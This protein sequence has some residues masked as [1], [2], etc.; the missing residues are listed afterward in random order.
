MHDKNSNPLKLLFIAKSDND[1][2]NTALPATI[3]SSPSKD[4]LLKF[5]LNLIRENRNVISN[6]RILDFDNQLFKSGEDKLLIHCASPANLN[7][8]NL[9]PEDLLETNLIQILNF[10]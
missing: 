9:N 6:L 2:S 8:V 7:S 1:L 4:I 5:L 3:I 10:F